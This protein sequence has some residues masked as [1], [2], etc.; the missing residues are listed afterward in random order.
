MAPQVDRLRRI[1]IEGFALVE[2]C[3]GWPGKSGRLLFGQYYGAKVKEPVI[4]SNEAAQYYDG[5]VKE[6]V[7]NSDE[8][9]QYYDGFVIVDHCRRNHFD[10]QVSY[11]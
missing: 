3:Y 4:A 8:A 1:G 5:M 11:S 2:D 9:A 7:I 10:L 6:P